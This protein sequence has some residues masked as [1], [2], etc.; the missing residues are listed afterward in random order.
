METTIQHDCT[1]VYAMFMDFTSNNRDPA[2]PKGTYTEFKTELHKVWWMVRETANKK[3]KD[4]VA[5]E[6]TAVDEN[7]CKVNAHSRSQS[8]SLLDNG[9]NYCNMSNVLRTIDPDNYKDK[10]KITIEHDQCG[11]SFAS[12]EP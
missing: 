4:D 8:F 6:L 7:S 12:N 2:V 9:V 1:W 5:F 10:S 3:Y 11:A